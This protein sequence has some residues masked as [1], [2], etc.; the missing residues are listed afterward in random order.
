MMFRF[1]TATTALLIATCL[2]GMVAAD[3][4]SFDVDV[5]AVLSKSGCN[6]GVCH[7][8][9]NGKGGFRLS[10]RGESPQRDHFALTRELFGRRVNRVEPAKSLLLL[11]ASARIAH[12]G[13]QRFG[14]DDPAYQTLHR[15]IASGAKREEGAPK[16]SR[17]EVSPRE[18][19]VFGVNKSVVLSVKATFSDGTTRDVTR[20]AVYE[21]SNLRV[22]VSDDG[23]V[24]R[25]SEGEATVMVRYL[26]GREPMRVAFYPDRR[27]FAW[28]NPPQ[29]NYVDRHVNTKLQRVRINPSSRCNDHIFVRRAYLDAIGLPPT[30]EE[31]RRFVMDKTPDKR[32]RLIDALLK[33]D[34]F[35][36][37]WALK[38][39]DLLRV[40]EKVLDRKGVEVFHGWIRQSI[41][42]GKPL[43][44]FAR[45][46]IA[47][48]GSTYKSPPSNYYRALR[49]APIRA[50]TTA[51]VFLGVRMQCAKC[52]NHPFEQ[53]T[54]DDYYG[55]AGLF[56][57]VQFKIVKNN[58][59]DKFDKHEFKGEQV[60]WMDDN[61]EIEDPRTGRNVRPRYLGVE[62]PSFGKNQDRLVELSKWITSPENPYFAQVQANRIWY[63]VIGRGL[64]A[65]LDDFRATNP[66][67][68]PVLLAALAKDLTDHKFDLRH[69]IRTIMNSRTYQAS[70][71]LNASNHSDEQNFSQAHVRRLSAEQLL[72]SIRQL[73]G[74]TS[75]F[76]GFPK[77]MRASQLPGNFPFSHPR[78]KPTP[79]D[80]L[81]KAFG[82]P[83][84]LL[85]CECERSNETTLSQAFLLISGG[86]VHESLTNKKGRLAKL[87]S[88][89][90]LSSAAIIDTL[91]WSALSRPPST[92]E[93]KRCE[94]MLAD[95]KHRTVA[96]QDI[97]WALINSKEF[98]LRR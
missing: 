81:L 12:Q 48:R 55:W 56:S 69:L 51:A 27:D 57:R 76:E 19:I 41:A 79:A 23:Q 24:R 63:H 40:E 30:G 64:V 43:D 85:A 6:A 72:D 46:I 84:R 86:L 11:K 90:D 74:T 50:E 58:R 21:P 87:A 39:A 83:D 15:W 61:T 14:A 82:K 42:E 16:V 18:M 47:A 34:E 17:L 73:T 26:N 32:T 77:G 44:Q 89:K 38:W 93:R 59:K 53:W 20:L 29:Q 52:H 1:I 78:G 28:S 95:R 97:G 22:S 88:Q 33:R 67:S 3:D 8:N 35:A 45:E 13:G 37:W 96:V 80:R 94:A 60:V 71:E 62:T 36:D 68:N 2:S 54:Q 49:K 75:Q 65:P 7:G 31:A 25:V 98:L 5:M 66:A 92:E 9:Q 91:Y 4:I 70:S 10:L